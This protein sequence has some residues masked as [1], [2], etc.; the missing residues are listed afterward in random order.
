[1]RLHR[2]GL[3]RLLVAGPRARHDDCG[4]DVR[5]SPARKGGVPAVVRMT[6]FSGPAAYVARTGWP[7]SAAVVAAVGIVMVA[8]AAGLTGS[9]LAKPEAG[10]DAEAQVWPFVTALLA[11]QVSAIV[12]TLLASR[13]FDSRPRDVLALAPP[14][15]GARIY[16]SAFALMLALFGAYSVAVWLIDPATIVKDL[17][18]FSAMMRSDA[19][20]LAF[21]A[22]AVGAPLMEE[23]LFRGFLLSALANS[24][25]GFA[26]GSL[27]TALC[28]TAL[29]ASYSWIGLVEVLAAGLYFSWLLWRTGSLLVPMFCHAAYNAGVALAL[30]VYGT[31]SPGSVFGGG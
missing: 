12:L 9:M 16:L 19:W 17:R 5:V 26:A 25:L 3:T 23:L 11:S 20:L 7:T 6:L 27:V 28:W 8:M 30:I 29:H 4:G 22:I 1:M 2:P 24:R 21:I 31:S 18:P 15:Q 13:A 10:A 14:A